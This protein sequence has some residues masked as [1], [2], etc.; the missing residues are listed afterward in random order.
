MPPPKTEMKHHNHKLNV[1]GVISPLHTWTSPTHGVQFPVLV[2][3]LCY[4]STNTPVEKVISPLMCA[5]RQG[6]DHAQL[7]HKRSEQHNHVI[8]VGSQ[9]LGN[10]KVFI[11]HLLPNMQ[12]Q[13]RKRSPELCEHIIRYIGRQSVSFCH[14]HIK[15]LGRPFSSI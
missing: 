3:D 9:Q 2:L 15:C 11:M 8:L 7:I 10:K 4:S 12:T 5:L 1:A 14:T 6:P 13:V